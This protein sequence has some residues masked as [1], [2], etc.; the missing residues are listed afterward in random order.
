MKS[1]DACMSIETRIEI[2]E[3]VVMSGVHTCPKPWHSIAIIT[4]S[5][6]LYDVSC[7]FFSE[8]IDIALESKLAFH[9][10]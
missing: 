1:I 8:R 7:R 2:I 3:P 4:P 5:K 9:P 10:L 6:L